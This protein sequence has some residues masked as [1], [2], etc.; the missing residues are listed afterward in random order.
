MLSDL[1]N[2]ILHDIPIPKPKEEMVSDE[3]LYWHMHEQGKKRFGSEC[4]HVQVIGDRCANC[5]RKVVV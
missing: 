5:L 4:K 2:L 1:E 3:S